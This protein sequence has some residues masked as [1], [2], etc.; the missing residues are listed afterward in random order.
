MQFFSI[1][2]IDIN[3]NIENFKYNKVSKEDLDK[4]KAYFKHEVSTEFFE[5]SSLEGIIILNST[6]FRGLMYVPYAEPKRSV[7]Q[8]TKENSV[9]IKKLETPKNKKRG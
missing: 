9:E 4:I 3:E 7:V 2:L 5:F 8:E 6:Y 1:E